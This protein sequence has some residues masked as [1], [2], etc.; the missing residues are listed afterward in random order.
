[1]QDSATHDENG[2]SVVRGHWDFEYTYFAGETASHFLRVIRD[3]ARILGK[4]CEICGR[5]LVPPRSFCDRCFAHTSDWLEVGPFGTVETFTIL[6]SVIAGYADPPVIVAYVTLDNADTAIANYLLN[7]DLDD[8]DATG[9]E[10]A[11]N[12]PR[13]RTVFADQRE[14]S[15]RD[16]HFEL[17]SD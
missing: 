10:L 5:V 14:G 4:K 2:I 15:V 12:P 16:F 17:L 1:M 13:V 7:I 3:E 6:N 8:I 9:R 11:D